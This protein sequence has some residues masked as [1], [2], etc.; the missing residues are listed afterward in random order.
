MESAAGID[1]HVPTQ[2]DILPAVRIER[3]K[4]PEGRKVRLTVV[5]R[6]RGEHKFDS[7]EEL[8]K[9]IGIDKEMAREFFDMA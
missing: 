6:L 4:Q 3:R 9:Q 1:E 5:K 8:E 2:V 7:V